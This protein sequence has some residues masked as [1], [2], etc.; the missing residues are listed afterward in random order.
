MNE[1]ENLKIGEV[2]KENQNNYPLVDFI[3]EYVC[4]L[5]ATNKR[6]GNLA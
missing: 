3:I 4:A 2:R 6:V 5:N 1:F